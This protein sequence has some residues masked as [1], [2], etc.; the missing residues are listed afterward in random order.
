MKSAYELAI[1][2]AGVEPVKSL[3]E[4]QKKQIGKIEKIYKAKRV[5]AE[6]SAE[7]RIKKNAGNVEEINRIKEDLLVE[8]ASINSKLEREKRTVGSGQ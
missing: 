1:E 6:L 4:D 5:E 3:T 2:R 7:S 8:L